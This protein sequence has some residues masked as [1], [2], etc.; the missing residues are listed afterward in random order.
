M[1]GIQREEIQRGNQI[2]TPG[3]F[4]T[5]SAINNLKFYMASGDITAG[6]VK[7]YGVK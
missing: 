7:M 2:T 5:T 3:Y 1:K 4:K 6:Q